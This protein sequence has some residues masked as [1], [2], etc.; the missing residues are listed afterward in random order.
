MRAGKLRGVLAGTV[1]AVAFAAPAP[2]ATT[3]GSNLSQAP[4][5]TIMDAATYANATVRTVSLASGGLT[6]P[7]S[8]VITSWAVRTLGA[9]G[10]TTT[11]RLVVIAGNTGIAKGPIL[12]APPQTGITAN[13]TRMPVAAGQRLGLEAGSTDGN[14]F[15]PAVHKGGGGSG[16][17]LHYWNPPLAEGEVRAPGAPPAILS[18]S[19][20]EL[21]ATIEPDADGDGFGDETQDDCIGTAGTDH[22]CAPAVIP[23]PEPPVQIPVVPPRPD[24]TI[25]SGPTKVRKPKATFAFS[26]NVAR[27]TFE[28]ALDDFGFSPCTS[29]GTFKRLLTGKHRFRVRAVSPEGLFDA[30]PAEQAF[31]VKRKRKP[32]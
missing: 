16:A 14:I 9:S 19:Q 5:N 23:D 7:A 6:A 29:P 2:A 28:C 18:D 4:T 32:K 17:L 15:L 21:Q 31:K 22:G 12:P 24:T 11:M 1:C 10:P 8:G 26:S 27:A 13:A 25:T 30:S 3:I 20:L